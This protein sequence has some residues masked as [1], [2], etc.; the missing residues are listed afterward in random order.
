MR[1]LVILETDQRLSADVTRLIVEQ[2][3]TQI[4]DVACMVLS[5]GLRL[6]ATSP[7]FVPYHMD[8]EQTAALREF[9]ESVINKHD[10][11]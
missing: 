11:R 7:D 5:D 9:A 6:V 3:K 4:P 10:A 1:P 8:D 2:C